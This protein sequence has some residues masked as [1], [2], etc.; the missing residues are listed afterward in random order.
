MLPFLCTF[1]LVWVANTSQRAACSWI[2]SLLPN[3]QFSWKTG[4]AGPF[5]WFWTAVSNLPAMDM[6]LCHFLPKQGL[7]PPQ[8]CTVEC[9]PE[10]E[11]LEVTFGFTKADIAISTRLVLFSRLVSVVW[12]ALVADDCDS[13][14]CDSLGII[15]I[16]YIANCHYLLLKVRQHGV[17]SVL[18]VGGSQ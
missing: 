13:L 1:V 7:S 16:K 14:T 18:C 8:V 2:L 6:G 5:H 11:D 15:T 4:C 10:M 9:T 17:H 12:C 3:S